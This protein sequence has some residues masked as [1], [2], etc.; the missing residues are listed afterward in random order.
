M[1]CSLQATQLL[2]AKQKPTWQAELEMSATL[3]LK[4]PKVVTS[5]KPETKSHLEGYLK[6]GRPSI[7]IH[8]CRTSS[9][10]PRP[11]S[12]STRDSSLRIDLKSR[13]TPCFNW[14]QSFQSFSQGGCGAQTAL[15]FSTNPAHCNRL[16][17]NGVPNPESQSK[18]RG[19]CACQPSR[20]PLESPVRVWTCRSILGGAWP[21]R[22]TPSNR[23]PFLFLLFF[24]LLLVSWN[25]A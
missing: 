15:A 17:N 23:L 2:V 3:M 10:G 11:A 9:W 25:P 16:S 1:A 8:Q 4:L 22:T 24:G 14:A 18:G 5:W 20:V 12:C 19:R 13:Y 21:L 6:S 7:R